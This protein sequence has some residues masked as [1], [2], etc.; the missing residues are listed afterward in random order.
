VTQAAL[1]DREVLTALRGGDRA[2]AEEMI[3]RTYS[4]VYASLFRMCGGNA[5]MAA[6]L[7]QETYQKAWQSIGSFEGKA[8][9]STWLYRIAYTTFIT[10]VRRPRRLVPLEDNFAA[11]VRDPGD[12]A[13]VQL[14]RGE[15]EERLRSAVLKLP[16]SL[17]FT[18]TAHF[19]G[20][21]AVKE[22]AGL[23]RVTTVAIRKR[24]YK[25]FSLIEATLNDGDA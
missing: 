4:G 5:D 1:E 19:W 23:E 22:I 7:T 3:E 6:D 20:E 25:A 9:F 11:Q 17:R 10:Q 24:L 21:L 2:A 8:K 13:E 15:Q 12:S 14:D 16:E 18:V